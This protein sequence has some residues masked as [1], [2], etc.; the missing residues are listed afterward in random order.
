MDSHKPFWSGVT[1]ILNTG[2][3]SRHTKARLSTCLKSVTQTFLSL[4]EEKTRENASSVCN[5]QTPKKYTFII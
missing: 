3:D 4:P 1:I 2:A 5:A